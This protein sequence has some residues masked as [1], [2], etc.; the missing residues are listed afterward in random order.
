MPWQDKY[1]FK[2]VTFQAAGLA[3]VQEFKAK[4][5]SDLFITDMEEYDRICKVSQAFLLQGCHN[6]HSRRRAKCYL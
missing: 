6:A 1:G 3:D 5:G 2:A 4:H